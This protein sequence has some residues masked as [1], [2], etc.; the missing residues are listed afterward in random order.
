MAVA[1]RGKV[2]APQVFAVTACR[3]K[4]VEA[5]GSER[6]GSEAGAARRYAATRG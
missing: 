4:K 2:R 3:Y 6:V 5:L 1:A